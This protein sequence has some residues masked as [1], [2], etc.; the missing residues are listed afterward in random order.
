MV[1]GELT[2]F[3]DLGA[4]ELTSVVSVGVSDLDRLFLYTSARNG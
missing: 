1:S 4:V 3:V 2:S